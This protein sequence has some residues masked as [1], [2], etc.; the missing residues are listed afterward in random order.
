MSQSPFS[1]SP[2]VAQTVLDQGLWWCSTRKKSAPFHVGF[3]VS[4][5]FRKRLPESLGQKTALRFDEFESCLKEESQT[6]LAQRMKALRQDPELEQR[7][8]IGLELAHG[9]VWLMAQLH[10]QATSEQEY[11]CANCVEVSELHALEEELV[12]SNSRLMIERLRERE[13]MAKKEADLLESQYRAQTQFLAML[14]HE[15]RSPLMGM[16]GLIDLVKQHYLDGKP[17]GEQLQVMRLT[18]DQLNF[19]INDILTFSQTQSDQ[20]RLQN[21]V[22]NLD[23]MI[24][25]LRHLTKSIASEKGLSV[26]VEVAAD[27]A[28]F[29]GDLVRTSQVL[30]NLLV[31]AIKFTEQGGV[32]LSVDERQTENSAGLVVRVCDSGPGIDEE[33]LR[34][35]FDPFKQLDAKGRKQ[36]VGSGLGLAI[37]KTLVELMGGDVQVRS[38]L[39][40]GTCF[41]VWLPFPGRDC[42]SAEQAEWTGTEKKSDQALFATQVSPEH[43]RAGLSSCRVLIADDSMINLRVLE[44]FLLEAGCQ[45]DQAS[46]GDQ[47]WSKFTQNRYDFVFLDIQMPGLNGMQVC[48]KIRALPKAECPALKGVFALTAA[49]TAAEEAESGMTLNKDLFDQWL[50]KPV[51]QDKV[52]HLIECFYQDNPE[53][54][55]A[56]S[57]LSEARTAK[58]HENQSVAPLTDC[59][60]AA[61]SA[62]ATFALDRVLDDALLAM[63]PQLIQALHEE[64]DALALAIKARDLSEFSAVLHRLKGNLMMFQVTPIL[65]LVQCL[66]QQKADC[67]ADPA[68]FWP[69]ADHGVKALE[70]LIR[71]LH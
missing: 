5:A 30:L 3:Y 7:F 51:S 9:T 23:E 71:R 16:N 62:M 69:I 49:H 11:I 68:E 44:T 47:A 19:L 64:C 13:Q 21:S 38:Q 67:Q 32:R 41:E 39:G 42:D 40:E 14:S 53:G 65:E 28:C 52:I 24:H 55:S 33:D 50:E 35:I 4:E 43:S 36:Y 66:Q 1:I 31:N 48:E 25:Y 45:V 46:D 54:C 59:L 20:I 60:Q 58:N 61:E 56:D 12:A 8:L 57:R 26:S 70:N 34:F 22:F 2:M 15:L 27:H 6:V 10:W 63:K 37:V 17:I 29:Y 18:I